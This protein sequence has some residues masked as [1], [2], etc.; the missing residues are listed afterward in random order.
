LEIGQWVV[1]K[2]DR[3]WYPGE[4]LKI[5]DDEVEVKRMKRRGNE[6]NRFIWPDKDDISWYAVEDVVCSVAPPAPVNSRAFGLNQHDIEKL[7]NILL[8]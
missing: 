1:V 4:I 6:E 7:E 8:T 3:N 2:F 5:E